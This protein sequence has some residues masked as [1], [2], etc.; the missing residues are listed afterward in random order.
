MIDSSPF[1]R[2]LHRLARL[3]VALGLLWL[4]FVALQATL[5]PFDGLIARARGFVAVLDGRL[6]AEAFKGITLG[7]LGLILA[8]CVF[9]IFLT[10]IDERA[11]ARGM[12]RGLVSAAVFY[13]SNELYAM[14]EKESRIHFLAALV[15]IVV[16]TAIV[17]EALSLAVRE[18]E[19][20]SFRTDVVSSIAS[21][22][23]F[24]V[25]LKL[26]EFGI[27]WITAAVARS[28]R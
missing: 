15:G 21:G 14:A 1:A 11:Y 13:L 26:G 23:L 7:G 12:W 22:L 5:H 9:P 6:S 10:R 3:L 8:L 28:A 19:Q 25:L 17:V 18:E 16:V 27:E 24:S 4:A 2:F 20:R